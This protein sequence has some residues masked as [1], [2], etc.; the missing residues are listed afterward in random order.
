MLYRFV[1]RQLNSVAPL[2]NSINGITIFT[3]IEKADF[4]TDYFA[5]V[6][7]SVNGEI[8]SMD[9]DKVNFCIRDSIVLSSL[10]LSE[11]FFLVIGH[12][13]CWAWLI[14]CMFLYETC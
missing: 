13:F 12:M 1:S 5:C 10:A 14:T 9:A 4:L 11:A 7:D 3:D 6:F 2:V 8:C